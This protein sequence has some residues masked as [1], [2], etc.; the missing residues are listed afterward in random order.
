MMDYMDKVC[1]DCHHRSEQ[2]ECRESIHVL[3]LPGPLTNAVQVPGRV[4]LSFAT[5]YP[6]IDARNPACSHFKKKVMIEGTG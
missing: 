5:A 4:G 1:G 2:G 6:K 3:M